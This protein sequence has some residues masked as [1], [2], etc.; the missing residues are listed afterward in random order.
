[1]TMAPEDPDSAQNEAGTGHT[2]GVRRGRSRTGR[3]R[4]ARGRAAAQGAG[5]A[6]T[7]RAVWPFWSWRR[8]SP[9]GPRVPTDPFERHAVPDSGGHHQ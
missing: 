9:A 5:S 8:W 7:G 4:P 2:L 3:R 1:M 6:G